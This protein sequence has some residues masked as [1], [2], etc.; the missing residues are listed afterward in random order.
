MVKVV[1]DLGDR[2]SYIT[3]ETSCYVPGQEAEAVTSY[4]A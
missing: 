4:L 2:E 1:I 3:N